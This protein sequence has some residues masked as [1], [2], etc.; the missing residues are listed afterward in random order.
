M[1]DRIVSPGPRRL[2]P[3]R[4]A[5]IVEV[6]FRVPFHDVDTMRVAWHGNYL[7]YFEYAR[8][9]LERRLDLEIPTLETLGYVFP[10]IESHCRHL[11]PLR[12]DDAARVRAWIAGADRKLTVG[13]E[14][15]NDT[16]GQRSA[17]GSTTQVALRADTFDLQ[18]EIPDAI[19]DRVRR[20][21]GDAP[22]LR[23]PR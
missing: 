19:L 14:V 23:G 12:F 1:N 2:R 11:S 22:G 9:A 15:L 6:A 20:V 10:V 21:L 8:T 5:V 3:P 13:Y 18:M 16:T 4:G 17:E 7:K